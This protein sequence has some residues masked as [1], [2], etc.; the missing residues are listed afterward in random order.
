V[1][2]VEVEEVEAVLY[3]YFEIDRIGEVVV[4]EKVEV[5]VVEKVKV[6][7]VVYYYFEIDRIVQDTFHSNSKLVGYN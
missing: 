2:E 3:Y 7:V 1:A 5:V 6:E 4:V